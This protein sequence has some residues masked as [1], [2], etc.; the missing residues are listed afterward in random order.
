MD[1]PG[2]SCLDADQAAAYA[3]RALG[4]AAR[5][6]VDEHIDACADCRRLVSE[7]A[8]H[9]GDG[10]GGFASAG[11]LP[12]GTQLGPY[13]IEA[14][15]DAGGMG[16]VYAARDTRLGRKVAL[17]AVRDGGATDAELARI[18]A[19]G[20]AMARVAHP[21]VVAVYDVIERDGACYL[22]MELVCGGSVRQWLAE[23]PRPWRDIV[24]VFA[25]AGEGLAAVHAAGL[26]HRDIKPA[27]LVRGDD[28]RVRIADFG[29]AIAA[30]P[31]SA[32]GAVGT[33]AYM[34]PEVLRGEPADARSDQY[35]LCVA[36]HEA[37][38]GALPGRRPERPTAV[39]HRVLAA[40]RRGLQADPAARF[41]SVRALLDELAAGRRRR[42]VVRA[43]AV[44]TVAAALAIGAAFAHRAATTRSAMQACEAGE[45]LSGIW[46]AERQ[47]EIEGALRSTGKPFAAAAWQRVQA[48][49][50]AWAEAYQRERRATCAATWIAG[51][52][53]APRLQARLDCL[54]DRRRELRAITEQLARTDATTASYAVSAARLPQ[55][56]TCATATLGAP[57][58]DSAQTAQR[59]ALRNAGAQV[60]A[61][62]RT[63]HARD[64][65]PIARA[66]LTEV[67][68][69]GDDALRADALWNLGWTE[70]EGGQLDAAEAHLLDA[71]AR[72]ERTGNARTRAE[73]W[74]RMLRIEHLRG[75]Y[76]RLAVYRAQAEAAVEAAGGA[77]EQRALLLQY[78]GTMH[79]ARGELA[80]A[81]DVLQRALAVD[82]D[83]P[84]WERG[85]VIESLAVAQLIAG[86]TREAID[87]LSTSRALI[88][89]DLGPSH[90]RVGFS[91]ENLAIAWFDLLELDRAHDEIAKTLAVFV[92]GFGTHRSVAIAHD[93]LGLIELER[94]DLGAADAAHRE[95]QRI[96]E[97]VAPAHPRRSVTHF[98]SAM[99]ALAAGR[100][101]DA[102]AHAEQAYATAPGLSEPKD[103]ALLTLGLARALCAARRDPIRIQ[104]LAREARDI[105]LA[106]LRSPRDDRDLAR[107]RR[108][109]AAPDELA[110]AR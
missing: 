85:T 88:E 83:M 19:E 41:P 73:A 32:R 110:S 34:A 72:A 31:A 25:A 78:V 106:H 52:Q 49:L 61:L 102:V 105:Y 59:T 107:A 6:A 10:G 38:Y 94:G 21:N 92:P 70:V 96:W 43:V 13:V 3:A 86:H 81:V 57:A 26:V 104:A 20:A 79:A 24:D 99:V 74:I 12:Q 101:A 22:A 7:A 47:R 82:P 29:L 51:S 109:I 64:A 97:A 11:G 27:N 18:V 98:G 4:D 60:H 5:Q 42:R 8:R 16:A 54:S 35:A 23:R 80:A 77:P 44:A 103:R 9:S 55:P 65:Q 108:L 63:G 91:H 15:I 56:A 36:L 76:D 87:L 17:K 39:P 89:Q 37:L 66:A 28:G 62:I 68:R 93:M 95:A 1:A 40:V 48:A 90:P 45:P 33:P 2:G 30:E 53:P 84:A 58:A 67:E 71:I 14:V 46:D 100:V 75:R 50:E 69:L